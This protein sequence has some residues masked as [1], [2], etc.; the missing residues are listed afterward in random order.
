MNLLLNDTNTYE[1][2][3]EHKIMRVTQKF[4]RA[5]R[6]LVSNENELGYKLIEY[7]SRILN[8]YCLS[9]TPKAGIPVRP[10]MSSI[11]RAH[12]P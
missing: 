8:L 12:W 2:I 6:K 5:I 4:N 10:I 3:D 9:K 11:G 7:H 1:K